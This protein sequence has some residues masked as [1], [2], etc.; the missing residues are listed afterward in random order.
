MECSPAAITSDARPTSTKPFRPPVLQRLPHDA[1]TFTTNQNG[2]APSRPT[3][4]N[5]RGVRAVPHD[6]GIRALLFP[7]THQG[8]HRVPHLSRPT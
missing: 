1:P 4:S 6:A 8:R 5:H 7:G 3:T 2:S